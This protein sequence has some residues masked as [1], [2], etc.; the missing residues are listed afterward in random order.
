[1]STPTTVVPRAEVEDL[2]AWALT[3][4]VLRRGVT[5]RASSAAHAPE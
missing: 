1:M 5:A 4:Y 2:L 3:G